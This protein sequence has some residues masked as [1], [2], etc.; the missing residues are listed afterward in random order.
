MSYYLKGIGDQVTGRNEI[1]PIFDAKINNFFAKSSPCVIGSEVN[2]LSGTVISRGVT[3]DSGMAFAFGY[4]GM[5]DAV[6]QF[7]FVTPSSATQYSKI[8]AEFNMSLNPQSFSIKVTPQSN[9]KI[10]DLTQDDLSKIPMGKFQLPLYLV[11]IPTN[12]KIT[13]QDLRVIQNTIGEIDFSYASKNVILD[14]N[15]NKY[16]PLVYDSSY[17]RMTTILG[18]VSNKEYEVEVPGRYLVW[19]SQNASGIGTAIPGTSSPGYLAIEFQEQK[20]YGSP[21]YYELVIDYSPNLP[22]NLIRIPKGKN[23]NYWYS[24]G[25]MHIFVE[26]F[27]SPAGQPNIL[28]YPLGTLINW[29][30]HDDCG[31]GSALLICERYCI[32]EKRG[33]MLQYIERVGN[34]NQAQRNCA[35]IEVYAII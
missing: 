6:V 3:V 34:T 2:Q 24:G 25:R 17:N 22:E 26:P 12:G 29:A 23:E 5:S 31:S 35:L 14:K 11:T 30:D 19:R 7:N 4:F 21:K 32:D 18:G 9:S 13:I 33:L 27:T 16:R 8:Y 28:C 20:L 1:S 15:R 10:I